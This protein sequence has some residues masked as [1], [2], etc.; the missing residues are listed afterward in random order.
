MVSFN[1]NL[2][3]MDSCSDSTSACTFGDSEVPALFPDITYFLSAW[4]IGF[5]AKF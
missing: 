1:N 4:N 5:D 3:I 2:V